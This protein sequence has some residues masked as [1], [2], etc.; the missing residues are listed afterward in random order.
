MRSWILGTVLAVAA[1]G[2]GSGGPA[3]VPKNPL[4]REN[5][6]QG[7]APAVAKAVR[8]RGVRLGGF[9]DFLAQPASAGRSYPLQRGHKASP[10]A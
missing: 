2:C 7:A 9:P 8:D 3:E 6:G 4:P 5:P 1:A 10:S